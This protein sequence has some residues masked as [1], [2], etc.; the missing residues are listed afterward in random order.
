[1]P[2]KRVE[3]LALAR[4]RL[5]LVELEIERVGE[6]RAEPPQRFALGVIQRLVQFQGALQRRCRCVAQAL[7]TPVA[8]RPRPKVGAQRLGVGAQSLALGFFLAVPDIAA[9]QLFVV[10]P[11]RLA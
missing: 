8:V 6:H 1:M 5:V 3:R 11:A 7:D 4:R 2:D 10:G 9:G